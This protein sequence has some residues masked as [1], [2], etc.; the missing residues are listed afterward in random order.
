[1]EQIIHTVQN[2]VSSLVLLGFIVVLLFGMAGR[3]G[4]P[5]AKAI[6]E[7]A[8]KFT[9]EL[10]KIVANLVAWLFQVLVHAIT[11]VRPELEAKFDHLFDHGCKTSGSGRGKKQ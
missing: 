1:M 11:L 10:L 2:A 8:F 7:G 9:L 5:V 6:I 4:T 3:D